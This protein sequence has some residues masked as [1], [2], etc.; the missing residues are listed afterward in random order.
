MV[1]GRETIDDLLGL[2]GACRGGFGNILA[3]ISDHF[4]DFWMLFQPG[5]DGRPFSVGKHLKTSASRQIHQKRSRGEAL[6]PPPIIPPKNADWSRDRSRPR[7]HLT[8]HGGRGRGHAGSLRLLGAPLSACASPK[9]LEERQASRGHTS[10]GRNQPWPTLREHLVRTGWSPTEACAH[11]EDH[12]HLAFRTRQSSD[13]S[14]RPPRKVRRGLV[15]RDANHP[16]GDTGRNGEDADSGG[17][18]PEGGPQCCL[19][20]F[21]GRADS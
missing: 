8:S 6:L 1:H 17:E 11:L 18:V 4:F 13:G 20:G 9:G 12:K 15:A 14:L 21:H 7:H 16:F 3:P 19:L 10:V 2:G 5:L